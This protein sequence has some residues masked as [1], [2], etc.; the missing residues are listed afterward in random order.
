MFRLI[1]LL[2][3]SLAAQAGADHP[4]LPIS[5]NAP[6]FTLPGVDGKTHSLADYASSPVLVIVFTCNHCPI[7]QVY[8]Q[9]IT[10]LA[11]DYGKRGVA[12]VAI[13]PNAPE[14]LR[15]DELDCSD[16][17]DSL[18]EMKIRVGYKHLEYP[19]LYDGE[20]QQTARAYGP[21][22][23]PHVFVFDAQRKLRY[24]GRMDDNYRIER[25]KSQD[26]RA[27]LDAVLAGREVAVKHTG[28]FGCSTKWKEKEADRLA[29]DRKLDSQ[30]VKLELVSADGLKQLR[31][32]AGG[33]L[34]LVSFWA[35]WCGSCVHEFGDMETTYRMYSNRNLAFVTVAANLPEE[36]EGVMRVLTK[37]HSTGRNLLF[38][39][40]KTTELQTAFDPEWDSAVPYT[41]L[42]G[43]GGKLLYRKLGSV[44]ILELRRVILKNLAAEYEGFSTYWEPQH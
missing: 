36:R 7:A 32:N 1:A 30:P 39:S 22:A 6:N 41:A 34:T 23:T 43:P 37:N 12:V 16:I 17:S 44:D 33:R 11:A 8:E 5:S 19:Y 24:E 3:L 42:V 27:A 31:A 21:Q 35:T 15:V 26:A 13:Q 10:Q 14:A 25:V 20:T 40:D 38:D 9:R 28:V 18:E 29:A 2:S 4:I